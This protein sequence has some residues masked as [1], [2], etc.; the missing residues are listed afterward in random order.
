MSKDR[1][2]RVGM[3]FMLLANIMV[4]VLLN[5]TPRSEQ[6]GTV[7]MGVAI[8]LFLGGAWLCTTEDSE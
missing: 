4:T 6:T 3:V 8:V 1:G 5:A 2:A 7:Y